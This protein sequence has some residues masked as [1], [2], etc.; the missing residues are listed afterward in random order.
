MVDEA[1]KSEKAPAQLRSWC[2]EWFGS[3]GDFIA[4]SKREP[5]SLAR[6]SGLENLYAI[7][8]L[9]QDLGKCPFSIACPLSPRSGIRPN[10]S[11]ATVST[12]RN[13]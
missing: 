8:S 10:Q 9:E 12:E 4:G 2:V 1:L 7:G 11:T 6:L 13:F 5:I 3:Q